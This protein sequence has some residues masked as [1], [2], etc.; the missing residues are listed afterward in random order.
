MTHLRAKL[1]VPAFE[2]RRVLKVSSHF[3]LLSM[4]RLPKHMLYK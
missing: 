3:F 4:L 2:W 1:D